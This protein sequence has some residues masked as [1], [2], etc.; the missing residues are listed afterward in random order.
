M[1]GISTHWAIGE[2]RYK[3]AQRKVGSS[4][5]GNKVVLGLELERAS[6]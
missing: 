1:K 2:P 4:P 5:K 6:F 3:A